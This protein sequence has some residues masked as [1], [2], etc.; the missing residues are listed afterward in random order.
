VKGLLVVVFRGSMMK[1]SRCRAAD[2]RSQSAARG[3]LVGSCAV[4]CGERGA[5]K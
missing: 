2:R 4:A 1:E 3:V 5:I